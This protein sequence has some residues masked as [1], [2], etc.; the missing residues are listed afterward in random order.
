MKRMRVLAMVAH[1]DDIEMS[2]A[3]TLA[4]YAQAGHTVIMCNLCD[5]A[6]GGNMPKEE[7]AAIRR[8]EAA[9]AA[10]VIGAEYIPAL[11]ED[12]DLY[13]DKPTRQKVA[14]IIR[15]ACPD[16]IITHPPVD[17]A[18]DHVT[19]SQLVFDASFLATLPNYGNAAD[20]ETLE[21]GPAVPIFYMEAA[22]GHAFQPTIWIDITE[23][24][25]LKQQMLECHAS[26]VKWLKHW[27]GIDLVAKMEAQAR[28][29]GMQSGVEYA[30]AFAV[31]YAHQ[32]VRALDFLPVG[33]APSLPK[34]GT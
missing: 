6:L 30:E 14:D 17:Y 19:T 24:F 10:A 25:E 8:R 5:G 2:C 12:L 22:G 15:Q 32:R 20:A 21:P 29:R 23:T 11:F 31:L 1:P 18:P 16:F 7:L 9:A 28:H 27:R 13:P 26:Q 33:G 4:K 34:E 3:G